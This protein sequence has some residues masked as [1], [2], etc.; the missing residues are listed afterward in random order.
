MF[1]R[2][3]G[4]AEILSTG[5][6]FLLTVFVEISK[7]VLKTIAYVK[8]LHELVKLL[9]LPTKI[10]ILVHIMSLFESGTTCKIIAGV[11]KTGT[12]TGQVQN[13]C[14]LHVSIF[15]VFIEPNKEF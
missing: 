5:W 11:G 10:Q 14:R 4:G 9:H 12:F 13:F 7:S 1:G 8:P 2:W 6:S 15:V 3:G